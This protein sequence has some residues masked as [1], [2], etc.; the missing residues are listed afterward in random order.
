MCPSTRA[1]RVLAAEEFSFFEKQFVIL[2][3]GVSPSET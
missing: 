2:G 3:S 1:A